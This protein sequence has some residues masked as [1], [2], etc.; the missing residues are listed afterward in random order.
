[1][2]VRMGIAALLAASMTL[3]GVGCTPPTRQQ[4]QN[5]WNAIG[6]MF[7]VGLCQNTSFCPIPGDPVG[8]GVPPTVPP[9][10]DPPVVD[11]P[12]GG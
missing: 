1:M 6:L 12:A 3:V 4:S 11:P 5:F 8:P 9:V 2:K 10:V 7:I